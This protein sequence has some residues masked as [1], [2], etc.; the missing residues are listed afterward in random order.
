MNI[1]I[2]IFIF[3]TD[4]LTIIIFNRNVCIAFGASMKD[5]HN[6]SRLAA[7]DTGSV[8]IDLEDGVLT[9]TVGDEVLSEDDEE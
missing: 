1:F 9:L 3:R 2:I 7:E 4:K 5:L 8:E 6:A